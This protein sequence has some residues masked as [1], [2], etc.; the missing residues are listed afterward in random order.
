MDT[1][2]SPDKADVVVLVNEKQNPGTYE[3]IFDG[4]N[5]S[6]GVYMYKLQIDNASGK[7]TTSPLSIT[8][9]MVLIK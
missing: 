6:S 1:N 9:K 3:I 2:N 4:S 7:G 8:K 5:Y